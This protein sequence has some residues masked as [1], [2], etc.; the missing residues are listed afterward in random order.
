ML[1]EE[2]HA[3]D[4]IKHICFQ[5]L[6]RGAKA[7]KHPFRFVTLALAY[8]N[9]PSS[10]WV[11]HRKFTAEQHVLIFTDNRSDKMKALKANP[12]ASL[13]YYHDRHSLQLRLEGKITIHH[14]NEISRKYW[15]GVKGSGAK[16]YI[17]VLPPGT[18]IKSPT[19]AFNWSDDLDDTHFVVLEFKTESLDVL[20]LNRGRH[21]RA[22]F[23]KTEN[24]WEGSFLVP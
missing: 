1:I 13:L 22:L 24:G 14:Q 9:K 10:R 15:P 2:E 16:D 4:E 23:N 7:R 6:N 18:P 11:V 19:A 12:E 20:Q 8:Q 5:E 3:L 21:I 17:S